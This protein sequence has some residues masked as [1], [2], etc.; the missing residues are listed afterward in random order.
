MIKFYSFNVSQASDQLNNLFSTM[1]IWYTHMYGYKHTHTI[2]ILD[3]VSFI[4]NAA[5][6]DQPYYYLS[7]CIMVMSPHSCLSS[8]VFFA[9]NS[10]TK[11]PLCSL[12][13]VGQQQSFGFIRLEESPCEAIGA[14]HCW[15]LTVRLGC[16][17]GWDACLHVVCLLPELLVPDL[18]SLLASC[19]E[20]Q[21]YLLV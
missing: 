17:W 13:H 16:W 4:F 12:D 5:Q 15:W 9:G 21:S 18:K 6:Y 1:Y 8:R 20:A 14:I 10:C 11:W 19:F 2:F 3:N 7:F